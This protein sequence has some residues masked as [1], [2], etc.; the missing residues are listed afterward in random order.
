MGRVSVYWVLA[1]TDHRN[2]LWK[3]V[4]SRANNCLGA[5]RAS[6]LSFSAGRICGN[7]LILLDRKRRNG[8][9]LFSTSLKRTARSQKRLSILGNDLAGLF[10]TNC[11]VNHQ[12]LGKKLPKNTCRGKKQKNHRPLAQPMWRNHLA[13]GKCLGVSASDQME[14]QDQSPTARPWA[15]WPRISRFRWDLQDSK[16]KVLRGLRH[17]PKWIPSSCKQAHFGDLCALTV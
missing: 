5:V 12:R 7:S 15:K 1:V 11:E 9:D 13:I 17:E 4:R 6:A 8:L 16:L 2:E 10:T 14:L 3:S